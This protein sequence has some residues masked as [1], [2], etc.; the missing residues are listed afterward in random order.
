[1]AKPARKP[2][3]HHLAPRYSFNVIADP[4]S[5]YVIKYPDLPK[6]LTQGESL[7]E[8]PTLA[9]E[10]PRLWIETTYA[11]GQAIPVPSQPGEP[12]VR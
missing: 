4:D 10:A 5:G 9:E 11:R 3:A 2:I 1:M 6:Y 12:F 7:A 8:I